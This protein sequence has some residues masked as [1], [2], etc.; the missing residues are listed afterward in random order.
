M[1]LKSL[2]LI[3]IGMSFSNVIFDFNK[4]SAI[5]SWKIVDDVVMGGRSTGDFK[6]NIN[7]HGEFSGAVSLENN[8]GFSSVRH[9]FEKNDLANYTRFVLNIKG[10]GKKYQFRVK[11]NTSDYHSYISVIQTDTTWQTI[12][13]LFSE[14][15]P[16]FRGRELNMANY[17]AKEMEEIAFLIGNKKRERFK[18]QI[19]KIELK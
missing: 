14:M 4:E 1:S 9:R 11:S 2:L 15:Y 8:G 17:S 10:D 18:L 12:E 5:S 19:D 3:F 13:I 7:G 6:L 16:S